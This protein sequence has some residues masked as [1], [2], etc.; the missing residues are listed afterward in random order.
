[1]IPLFY[2]LIY[3][4]LIFN[5]VNIIPYDFVSY[6]NLFLSINF[7]LCCAKFAQK[8][9]CFAHQSAKFAQQS[10]KFAYQSAK[11]AY[12][13]AKFEHQIALVWLYIIYFY[14][15]IILRP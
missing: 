5:P 2:R 4:F 1:L 6:F 3:V 8:K 7:A 15:L 11:F 10:A 14:Q 9:K 12:Q 13:S